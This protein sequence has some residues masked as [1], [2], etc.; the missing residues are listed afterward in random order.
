MI[1]TLRTE[2][3]FRLI[4]AHVAVIALVQALMVIPAWACAGDHDSVVAAALATDFPIE[5][6]SGDSDCGKSSAQSPMQHNNDCLISC[7]SSAGCGS[8]PY[9]VSEQ[10]VVGLAHGESSNPL[11]LE[12]AHPSRSLAPDRPPPRS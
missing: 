7:I 2:R 6:P 4:A 3:R 1:A 10:A 12:K 8:S 9:L 11:T 5:H